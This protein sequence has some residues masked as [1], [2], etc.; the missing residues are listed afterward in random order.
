MKIQEAQIRI[1]G[2]AGR[3]L[4][5]R[6]MRSGLGV[7]FGRND[8]YTDEIAAALGLPT[9]AALAGIEVPAEVSPK[10]TRRP[11]QEGTPPASR[12]A[13]TRQASA[14]APAFR[15]EVPAHPTQKTEP[16]KAV[17]ENQLLFL[18]MLLAIC[19]IDGIAMKM[20]G[21]KVMGG[22]IAVKAGMFIAGAIVA[23]A[24]IQNAYTLSQKPR[25]DWETNPAA[26]WVFVFTVYQVVLHGAAG[27]FFGD[28][29]KVISQIILATGVPMATAALQVLLFNHAK[30]DTK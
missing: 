6:V 18:V 24:G 29:N 2:V 22:D 13:A 28:W 8:E 15:G 16:K 26:G 3:G 5:K 4:E 20:I 23:Y 14:F 10:P 27:G 11:G 19:L 21:G 30:T 9:P 25:K 7:P 12:K 1:Y 17:F